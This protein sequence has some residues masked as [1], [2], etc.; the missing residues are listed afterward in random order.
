[1]TTPLYARRDVLMPR[2]Q[3]ARSSRKASVIL[4]TATGLLSHER[5]M[6]ANGKELL[7]EPAAIE[8]AA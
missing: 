6:I 1:M 4:R 8:V 5:N 7:V 2:K 3:G